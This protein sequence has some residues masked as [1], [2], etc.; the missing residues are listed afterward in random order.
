MSRTLPAYWVDAFVGPGLRGNPAAVCLLDEPLPERS[1][2]AISSEMG[3]SE[4]AFVRRVRDGSYALRWFTPRVEVPLCGHAT[5]ASAH[6]LYHER[7]LA[8]PSLLFDSRSGALRAC[9]SDSGIVLEFPRED[10]VPASL[11]RDLLDALGVREARNV[12]RGPRSSKFLVKLSSSEEVAALDPDLGRLAR[13][14]TDGP[15]EGIIVTAA[16]RPP[17]DFVSRF[18]HP[19]AGVPEDPVT[20]SAHTVLTP[21]WSE[22][23]GR[24]RMRARQ[25]SAR[26]GE[27]GVELRDASVELTGCSRTVARGEI[28]LSALD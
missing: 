11:P 26:G 16:G 14:V 22:R 8:D 23:T 6:V 19:W 27:I 20:G 28:D 17:I 1:H 18:F 4:T 15:V 24:A 7:G 2:L 9:R 13:S 5:L 12:L 3:L 10:P 21:Y 25:L